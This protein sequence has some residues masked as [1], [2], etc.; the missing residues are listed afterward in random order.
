[1]NHVQDQ[2]LEFI[3]IGLLGLYG[4]TDLV[5][6][7]NLLLHHMQGQALGH[8]PLQL[9]HIEQVV[10]DDAEMVGGLALGVFGVHQL[11]GHVIVFH[12]RGPAVL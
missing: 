1:M 10:Q 12:D 3:A 8:D 4:L 2:V 11:L 9:L 5:Q 6:I 7:G